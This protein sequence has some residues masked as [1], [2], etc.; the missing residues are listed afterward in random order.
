MQLTLT[1]SQAFILPLLASLQLCE[2]MAAEDA[3]MVSHTHE[4]YEFE[5]LSYTSLC[6][7][8]NAAQ[9]LCHK[10]VLCT[11]FKGEPTHI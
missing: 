10:A 8:L 6:K 7:N 3:F 11:S 4:E 1:W 5:S 9:K 2:H